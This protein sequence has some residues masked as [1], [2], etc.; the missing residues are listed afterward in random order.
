MRRLSDSE[1][2]T[3][4]SCWNYLGSLQMRDFHRRAMSPGPRRRIS[5]KSSL[6]LSRSASHNACNNNYF[7]SFLSQFACSVRWAGSARRRHCL[8]PPPP[9]QQCFKPS[10][11]SACYAAQRCPLFDGST[12]VSLKFTVIWVI[13]P[14]S[15]NGTPVLRCSHL[16]CVWK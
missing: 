9:P 2:E 3:I 8:A 16:F 5:G 14:H 7:P 4:L 6:S 15:I 1:L 11:F 10:L 13:F 12:S